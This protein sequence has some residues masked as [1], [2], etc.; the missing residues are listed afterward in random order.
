MVTS[1]LPGAA[2]GWL[3]TRG[4]GAPTT[5]FSHG[6]GG[7]IR[8]TRPFAAG[9][10]GTSAFVHLRGHGGRPSPGPGW[11]YAD[12]TE[13]LG[14]AIAASGATRAL[15]VSMSA[16]ALVRYAIERPWALEKIVMVL[17]A[18][19]DGSPTPASRGQ[20]EAAARAKSLVAAGDAEA[21]AAGLAAREPAAVREI[22]AARSWFLE[23]A[24]TLLTTDQ[25]DG[26]DLP[27]EAAIDDLSAL[28][29]VTA[30][31]L[32]LTHEEDVSHPVSVARSYAEHLPN[33]TLEVLP[34]GS[35]LWLGRSRVREIVSGFLND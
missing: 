3:L 18:A 13:E 23:R 15:G 24:R 7:S 22:P 28:A 31:V 6:F 27:W 12:L 4:S 29:T 5:L 8:D 34:A 2:D 14:A 10:A 21:L 16:G 25:K 33:A 19:L 30:P 20:Q 9:V 35:I 17:P 1:H 26:L 11:R 32:V